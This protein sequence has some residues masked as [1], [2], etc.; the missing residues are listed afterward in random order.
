[1]EW[2][3]RHWQLSFLPGEKGHLNFVR[4]VG[5]SAGGL[6]EKKCFCFFLIFVKGEI[7]R[8]AA[9]SICT[10]SVCTVSHLFCIDVQAPPADD[11]L[12]LCLMEIRVIIEKA[13]LAE[14]LIA[15]FAHTAV[16]LLDCAFAIKALFG[17]AV[18]AA[19][20]IIEACSIAE[21]TG[22]IIGIAR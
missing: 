7:G 4:W 11:L 9:D 13:V 17:E 18:L 3:G 14:G 20:T 5:D 21:G 10:H 19:N 15:P 8:L 2:K 6:E 16:N 12:G 22:I 1:L